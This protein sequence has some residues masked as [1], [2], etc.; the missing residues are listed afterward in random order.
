V[1]CSILHQQWHFLGKAQLLACF[2]TKTNQNFPKKESILSFT[3]ILRPETR[4]DVLSHW[5]SM[6]TYWVIGCRLDDM[7]DWEWDC[8]ARELRGAINRHDSFFVN[9]RPVSGI[10]FS[11]FRT[12]PADHIN[13]KMDHHSLS[14]SFFII[15]RLF[16]LS[17]QIKE[18]M[19]TYWVSG[20]RLDDMSDWEW[21]WDAREFELRGA[22]NRHDSFFVNAPDKYFSSEQISE[23]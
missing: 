19:S 2:K 1:V 18:E 23:E 3:R 13:L 16:I 6:S 5:S 17:I 4:F 11:L 15:I 14:S 7:S 22:I 20:F 10:R 12:Y 9:T 8:D 21:D